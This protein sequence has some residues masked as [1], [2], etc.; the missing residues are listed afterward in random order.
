[1]IRIP[2]TPASHMHIKPASQRFPFLRGHPLEAP[3]KLESIQAAERAG[4]EVARQHLIAQIGWIC[5]QPP[6]MDAMVRAECPPPFG[7]F[8]LA[9]TANASPLRST[10][11]GA[12]NP[13]AGFFS[14][15]AHRDITL[16]VLPVLV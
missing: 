4:P 15:N 5:P 10:L 16:P 3:I 9:P 8:G 1:M 7:Y 6:F 12:P 2:E 13:A 11:F 14:L